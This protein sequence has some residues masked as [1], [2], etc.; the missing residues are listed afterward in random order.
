MNAEIIAIGTELLIGQTVDTNAAWMGQELNKVGVEVVRATRVKDSPEDMVRS[1]DQLWPET[2]LVLLTGGLG[3]THDDMTKNVLLSYF[4]G[5]LIFIQEIYTHIEQ[6]FQSMGRVP[7]LLNRAQ[8][9]VPSTCEALFNAKGTAP[10]MRWEREGVVFIAMPGVPYEM[11]H[12]METYVLPW[13]DENSQDLILHHTLHTQ[14]VPESQ[15]AEILSSFEYELPFHVSLAYLPS[16][17]K[18]KLRLTWRGKKTD[19]ML[20]ERELQ[21]LVS[22]VRRAA[23]SA[24]YGDNEDSL[25]KMIGEILTQRGQTLSTAE[26]CSGGSIAAAVTSVSGSSQYFTGGVVAYS[27]E[28]KVS[29]LGVDPMDVLSQG[30]V[31]EV[32]VKQMA[33]GVKKR[34]CS[35]W[36]LATSGV[37]GPSGGSDEKPVG[38]V[39][40]ALSG[41]MG[42]TAEKFAMGTDRGRIVQ[43][44]VLTALNWLRR[45]LEKD[46]NPL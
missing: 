8:A 14:G 2:K 17:G 19:S 22:D 35:D 38:T 4:G 27:N 13:A 37:A 11:K 5:E 33:E 41:P 42:T 9:F 45:E 31:S 28:V 44:T 12:L 1:L 25:E 39:W 26:S 46:S 40:I 36:A 3:P 7:S 24:Y 15:L 23:E 16:P 43:K 34:L 10:G 29:Q 30:A 6:L 32:V 21:V 20:A 18:V